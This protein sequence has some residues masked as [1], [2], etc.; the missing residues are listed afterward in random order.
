MDIGEYKN[1]V[2]DL[3]KS[4]KATD[5]Q[6]QEL[7]KAVLKVSE[8]WCDETTAIDKIID[9]TWFEV[10]ICGNCGYRNPKTARVCEN[11]GEGT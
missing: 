6:W 8:T 5:E 1:K 2:I 3:F 7:G 10:E 4:G 11:C 9:P